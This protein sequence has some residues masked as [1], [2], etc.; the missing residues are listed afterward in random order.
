MLFLEFCLMMQYSLAWFLQQSYWD[1]TSSDIA[2]GRTHRR[3]SEH[4]WRLRFAIK[5]LF[6]WRLA[7]RLAHSFRSRETSLHWQ[8][9][10]WTWKGRLWNCL[11]SH[12]TQRTSSNKDGQWR[13]NQGTGQASSWDNSAWEVQ[14]NAHSPLSGIQHCWLQAV[15]LHGAHEGWQSISSATSKRWVSVVQQVSPFLKTVSWDQHSFY[16]QDMLCT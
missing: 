9:P 4:Q 8:P 13:P 1:S 15:A 14:V 6:I 7:S 5:L 16:R 11:W 3:S 2:R 12:S 10:S